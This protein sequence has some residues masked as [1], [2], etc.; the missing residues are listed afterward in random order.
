MEI[1]R[2][3]ITIITGLRLDSR[4]L[5]LRGECIIMAK[6]IMN[7]IKVFVIRSQRDNSIKGG[8]VFLNE[9]S[10]KS[11]EYDYTYSQGS[12]VY[13]DSIILPFVGKYVSYVSVYRGFDYGYPGIHDVTYKSEL[14]PSTELA[15][16][17]KA[18]KQVEQ[19]VI[20]KPEEFNVYPNKI[21][22]KDYGD[23]D[24]YYGDVMEGKVSAEIKRLKVIH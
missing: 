11:L 7:E 8:K 3:D 5:K 22:S 12:D 23:D 10:A 15:Q 20:E 2:S 13:L 1:G 21:C 4:L 18:W 9:D 14:Y 17:S 24:W 6:R 19:Q 16:S